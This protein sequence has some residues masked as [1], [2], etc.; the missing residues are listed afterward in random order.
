M[1]GPFA[2][3]YR[4]CSLRDFG[5]KQFH[6]WMSC[7][8]EV[9]NESA[10]C[11]EKISSDREFSH[12]VTAAILVFQNNEMVAM[13]VFQD[14]PVGDE[15]FSYVNTFICSDNFAYMLATWVKTLNHKWNMTKF[16]IFTQTIMHIVYPPP[17]TTPKFRITIVSNFS[18]VI[19]S[20][21]EKTVVMLN[22]GGQT[23]CIMVV[24]TRKQEAN[25]NHF[26]LPQEYQ[27][28]LL[29]ATIR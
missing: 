23:R 3:S 4:F 25:E 20:S 19:Q 24:N 6:C 5:G 26:R 8:L 12:D 1:L 18:W 29:S 10:R 22:F 9:T 28:F 13:L 15:P 7:D 14:N 21:Q 2:R 27:S 11:W 16:T 17:P